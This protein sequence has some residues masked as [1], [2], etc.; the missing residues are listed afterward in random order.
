MDVDKL[1]RSGVF[2]IGLSFSFNGGSWVAWT[3]NGLRLSL[4]V[5]QKK[6]L[7]YTNIDLPVK[8]E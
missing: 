3:R 8:E 1:E 5:K 7:G 6:I 4:A 2:L